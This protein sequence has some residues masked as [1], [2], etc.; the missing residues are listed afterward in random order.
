MLPMIP[1]PRGGFAPSTPGISVAETALTGRV[2][3]S[4][5]GGL[6]VE[7]GNTGVRTIAGNAQIAGNLF[8]HRDG[9]DVVISAAGIDVQATGT[10]ELHVLP[11]GFRPKA[12]A[13]ENTVA[14]FSTDTGG[15]AVRAFPSG[16]IH[17][18][19]IPA[20]PSGKDYHRLNFTLR[21]MTIQPW[22]TTLP[23][24]PA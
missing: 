8:L 14:Y 6:T 20:Y 7:V 10:H 22:P 1:T 13:Y 18:A 12:A 21:F 11:A 24:A 19:N 2:A 23:G 5:P 3:V 4:T 16:Q 17:I 15:L 9:T